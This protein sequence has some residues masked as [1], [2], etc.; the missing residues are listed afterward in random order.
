MQSILWLVLM[1]VKIYDGHGRSS[2]SNILKPM[3]RAHLNFTELVEFDGYKSEAHQVQTQDGYILTVFRVLANRYCDN[4]KEKHTILFQHGLYLSG[5]DCIIP[6]PGVAHCYIYS[7]NCH[8]VWVGNSRGNRYSRRHITKNPDKDESFWDFT[9]IEMGK[10]DL[11]AV[12]DYITKVTKKEQLV[13]VGHSEGVTAL[14]VLMAKDPRYN[15]KIKVGFGMSPAAWMNHAR[16]P[17][18]TLQKIIAPY[19]DLPNKEILEHGGIV[20]TLAES[21]C[22][23]RRNYFLCSKLLFSILGNNRYQITKEVYP[24]I[25]GHSSAGVSL[26]NFVYWGQI[27]ENG[28]REYDYG[29]EKNLKIYGRETPPEFNL[30]KVTMDLVLLCSE[31]D[32]V[33]DLKDVEVL[34]SHVAGIKVCVVEDKTFGHLDFVYG[35]DIPK[36]ITPKIFAYLKSK[37]LNC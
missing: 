9:F 10:Y 7:D 36:L 12:I 33:G 4:I 27:A 22:G 28:F 29:K 18:V 21:I 11:P 3:I 24:V 25:V 5:D 30:N 17:M 35:K 20:Q 8:D 2:P 34:R 37:I 26:K 31:N 19:I 13:Y 14:L 6:G 1:T 16:L 32:W 23:R 15:S